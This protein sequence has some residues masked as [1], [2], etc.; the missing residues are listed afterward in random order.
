MN[1]FTSSLALSSWSDRSTPQKS[2]CVSKDSMPACSSFGAS[3]RIHAIRNFAFFDPRCN[4]MIIPGCNCVRRPPRR[5]P[6]CVMSTVCARWLTVSSVTF[7][8]NTIFLRGEVR[9]FSIGRRLSC[10]NGSQK[11]YWSHH[12]L[13]HLRSVDAAVTDGA[14]AR[15]TGGCATG[16]AGPMQRPCCRCN[17]RGHS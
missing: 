14:P 5:A 17:W 7:T 3:C 1:A 11:S 15:I 13:I 6:V 10:V 12:P 4:V 2:F 9:L 16:R 8:G